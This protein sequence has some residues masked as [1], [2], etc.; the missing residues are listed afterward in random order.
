MRVRVIPR[1]V[2]DSADLQRVMTA[3]LQSMNEDNK[4]RE[5]GNITKRR[6]LDKHGCNWR[7]PVVLRSDL[8][9]DDGDAAAATVIRNF[10]AEYNIE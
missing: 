7:A 4:D 2:V 8:R 1:A 9:E 6:K 5:F 3:A 10:Q